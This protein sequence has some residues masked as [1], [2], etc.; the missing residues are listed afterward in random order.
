MYH[1]PYIIHLKGVWVGEKKEAYM[2]R[3]DFI[4]KVE[5]FKGL[6]DEQMTAVQ[7]CCEEKEFQRG[8]KI[9]GV[10]DEA[11][12]PWI[13]M[14]GQVDLR[15][16][17]PRR[18]TAEE[19]TIASIAGGKFLG[20]SSLVPPYKY[21]LSAYCASRTCKMI[22]ID[23]TKLTK[24]FEND[25]KLGRIIMTNLAVIIGGRFNQL[26]NEIVKRRGQDVM[27]NWKW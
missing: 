22:K 12:Y 1:L 26:E 11:R 4:E 3:L 15:F 10:G 18:P 25:F 2:V 16:D 17:L 27:S 6:N 14:E 8:D 7:N 19:N 21:R 24:L 5:A 20:W 13:V 23:R 9:F